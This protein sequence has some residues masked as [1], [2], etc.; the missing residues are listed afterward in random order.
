MSSKI[1]Q[2]VKESGHGLH[3]GEARRRSRRLAPGVIGVC[4]VM[5]LASSLALVLI[6]GASASSPHGATLKV[7]SQYPAIQS[8]INAAH[9]GDTILV[10]AASPIAS[11]PTTS[12]R[13]ALAQHILASAKSDHIPIEA[14][15]LPNLLGS[16]KVSGGVV[17]PLTPAAPA[18]MGI[19]TYGVMNTTGTPVAYSLE[20]SSWMG[21][22]TFNSFNNFLLAND[23]AYSTNGA[24]NTFGV[25]LNAVT[26]NSTVRTSSIYSFWTQNVLYFNFPAP[27]YLTFLDNVW[28]FSSPAVYLSPG[29]IFSGNGSYVPSV[30]YY[31]DF[32]QPFA[33]TFPLTVQLYLNSS[34]TNNATTG[35][36]YTTVRFGYLVLNAKTGMSE[37]SGV[38]DTVLF[39]S[40]TKIGHVPAS[41]Y[42]V[43]GSRVTPTGFI[44]WDAEIMVGG[45]G[46]GTTV[47][48]Y[49]I[50][51]SAS[52]KYWKA[53]T[54]SYVNAR[55]A[56]DQ[57][58]ET[59]ETSEGIA[60]SY[61]T[62]GTVW[63]NTGPSIVEPLWNATPGGNIGQTAVSGVI[64]P[65]NAFVFFTPGAQWNASYVS[66]A[67][68]Q[69]ASHYA[70]V[71]S[72]GTYTI[73][74]MLSDYTP[75]Q[76]TVT[77][78]N[79]ATSNIPLKLTWNLAEGVYTPLFAWNNAQLG[80]ISFGGSGTAAH[81]YRIVNNPSPGGQLN[82]TFAM[83]NDYLYQVFP[84]VLIAGTTAHVSLKNPDL[85]SVAYE[86]PYLLGFIT[87]YG[88]PST[89]N[90]Q[91]EVFDANYVTI[92]GGL[93]ITGWFFFDDYGPT[94][95]LPLA[96]VVI[97][98]GFHDLVGDNLFLSQG[99]SLVLA[100]LSPAVPTDNV[101]WGN[102]FVN[103]PILSPGMYPGN[104]FTSTTGPPIGIFAFESGDLIYNNMVITSITAFAPNVNMFTG[105]PQLNHEMWNLPMVK[106]PAFVMHF[107]GH[108]LTG[109]IVP[110]AWQ[111]G[112]FWWDYV[113]GSPLPYNEFGFIATGGDYFPLPITA[114]VVVFSVHQP[115]TPVE[116]KVTVNGVTRT[117][118]GDALVFFETPGDYTFMAKAVHD[119][120]SPSHGTL[121]VTDHNMHVT[122]KLH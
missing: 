112:N 45:P 103:S 52:L 32:S 114:Y 88:L 31:Y 46:G 75:I 82:T 101:V 84:G 21:S 63:L 55:D 15:S 3:D 115:V 39:N 11:T 89:N 51:G 100:G 74:A 93:G 78:A 27:G 18:P 81:P 16:A 68:T 109:T 67:P 102:T 64:S 85:L 90:L 23:G 91:F 24:Q 62:P 65:S 57:G 59:G 99:S 36:G 119:H 2:I 96:N 7:P 77:L 108:R 8:A 110:S 73:D 104:F 5:V 98:G 50:S 122:L 19:G 13:S 79:G 1:G 29:T 83:A 14:L 54:S 86:T 53:G 60:E 118:T 117:T 121:V 97:W 70:Y 35:Y 72:P 17:Q 61:M 76:T 113:P 105:A 12:A 69:T 120:I 9:S 87:H 92:W 94:G 47:S 80:A 43:D 40:T 106:R 22:I 42:L 41:P 34:I 71:L 58:S 48:F 107:N 25:Q 56:W 28:N 116:W 44:P 38:Y 6:P 26:N 20:T 49:G 4:L 10:G 95:L 30:G 66:W 111:G 33:Y 37:E